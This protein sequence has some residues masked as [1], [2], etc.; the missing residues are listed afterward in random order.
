MKRGRFYPPLFLSI[1]AVILVM[2]IVSILNGENKAT[3]VALKV[4]N[5]VN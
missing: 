4:V 2:A 5:T 1:L 3:L